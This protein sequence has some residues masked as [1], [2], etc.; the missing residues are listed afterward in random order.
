MRV[1]S[2]TLQQKTD[3]VLAELAD[4]MEI[5][6]S[7]P[8]ALLD[9]A[10]QD[11]AIQHV[12]LAEHYG[13]LASNACYE[14]FWRTVSIARSPSWSRARADQEELSLEAE[15][16]FHAAV[17]SLRSSC[18][19]DYIYALGDNMKPAFC[20]AWKGWVSIAHLKMEPGSF[21]QSLSVRPQCLDSET[22]SRYP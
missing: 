9:M 10:A 14:I 13:S 15:K 3:E 4:P 20:E 19:W 1:A 21:D 18:A 17:Q 6:E 5:D 12:L 22:A 16:R 8:G 7:G 2:R 11:A